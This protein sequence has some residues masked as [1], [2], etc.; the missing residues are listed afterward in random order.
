[1][2]LGFFLCVLHARASIVPHPSSRPG[3][4]LKRLGA[5]EVQGLL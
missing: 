5:L 3:G 4:V 1:M 2:A